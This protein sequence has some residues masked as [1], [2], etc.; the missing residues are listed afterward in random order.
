M[1][2]PEDAIQ[3]AC[4]DYLRLRKPPCIWFHPPNGGARTKAEAGIFKAMGVR[5]GV[6]DLIFLWHDRCGAIEIKP[7]K[8]Y[9]SPSQKV[10]RDDCRRLGI[11]W[12][13]VHSVD[14]LA[15]ILT[16]WGLIR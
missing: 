7:P 13:L 5:A 9:L 6:A 11:D 2:R 10:F 3:R 4:A 1:N 8:R 16:A 15:D 12:A 14:E